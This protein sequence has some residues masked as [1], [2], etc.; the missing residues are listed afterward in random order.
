MYYFKVPVFT[1]LN[2][3]QNIIILTLQFFI[4]IIS[5]L[6]SLYRG[7]SYETSDFD[8]DCIE[9][10][11]FP[12]M[13]MVT[14][15][16]YTSWQFLKPQKYSSELISELYDIKY[17]NMINTTFEGYFLLRGNIMMFDKKMEIM[18]LFLKNIQMM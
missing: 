16:T 2:R 18:Y 8:N 6:I 14:N 10:N 7:C 15:R 9:F 13:N 1:K 4:L 12:G 17:Y 5:I 11:I 3:T